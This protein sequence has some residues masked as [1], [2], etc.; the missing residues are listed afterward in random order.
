M[1]RTDILITPAGGTSTVLVFLPPGATAIVMSY[2][3]NVDEK[4]VQMESIYYWN[5]EY[6]DIQYFPVLLEDYQHT[7]DRPGCEKPIDDPYF[8]SQVI[9]FKTYACILFVATGQTAII[10]TSVEEKH[11]SNINIKAL[12]CT[13]HVDGIKRQPLKLAWVQT[14][15][16]SFGSSWLLRPV[17]TAG[18]TH[19]LQY[20]FEQCT[21]VGICH[22]ECFTT[23]ATQRQT[24]TGTDDYCRITR[25]QE[26]YSCV[27]RHDY[28]VL[29]F[30]CPWQEASSNE[31]MENVLQN[32]VPN[33][34][35]SFAIERCLSPCTHTMYIWLS[36]DFLFSLHLMRAP[37]IWA[38]VL[39][40]QP[41]AASRSG[42]SRYGG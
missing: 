35:S 34:R 37:P 18:S 14:I 32:S 27:Q 39:G 40:Q 38:V 29:E 8:D 33:T 28:Q 16:S 7:T 21:S 15:I 10:S 30:V 3:N 13:P 12:V 25:L 36:V 42:G 26:I 2:W 17:L 22:S 23:V 1:S 11:M 31:Q 5:L 24:L 41:R 4:S 6:L 20:L 9:H 19:W